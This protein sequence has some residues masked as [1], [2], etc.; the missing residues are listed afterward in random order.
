MVYPHPSLPR[1]RFAAGEGAPS[2]VA[3]LSSE[4]YVSEPLCGFDG[5]AE[6]GRDGHGADAAGHGGD[7]FGHL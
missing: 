3:G 5:V 7:V 2:R 4:F 6:Q 1:V